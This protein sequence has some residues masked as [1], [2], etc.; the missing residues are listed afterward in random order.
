MK[1]TSYTYKNKCVFYLHELKHKDDMQ[2]IKTFLENG[3][4][5]NVLKDIQVN[6]F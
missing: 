2:S 5:E 4:G 3:V 6:V 1:S